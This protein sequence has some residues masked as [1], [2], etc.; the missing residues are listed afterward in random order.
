[1]NKQSPQTGSCR[2]HTGNF[3]GKIAIFFV[4]LSSAA[5]A[6]QRVAALVVESN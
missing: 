5:V 2:Y 3:T 4:K 6:E 1:M